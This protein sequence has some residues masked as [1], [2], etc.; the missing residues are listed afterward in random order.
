MYSSG[1]IRSVVRRLVCGY[2]G[3][4]RSG[5][6][7]SGNGQMGSAMG[8]GTP[9]IGLE[10][11]ISGNVSGSVYIA[12]LIKRSL[13]GADLE[14]STPEADAI[15][16]GRPIMMWLNGREST[17]LYSVY[18]CTCCIPELC[19]FLFSLYA[20]TQCMLGISAWLDSVCASTRCMLVVGV[21]LYSVYACTQC[22]LEVGI[23]LYSAYDVLGVCWT[24]WEFRIMIWR[25]WE[26]WLAIVF[27]YG[28]RVDDRRE[29]WG[30]EMGMI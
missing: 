14:G 3:D 17:M 11:H 22:K 7:W 4:I 20:C 15:F 29:W 8:T 26:K 1:D 2:S 10:S 25:Y 13:V 18:V 23:Y 19:V 16:R 6:G 27:S 12:A 30:M 5:G 9:F 28:F 21:C 24:Q